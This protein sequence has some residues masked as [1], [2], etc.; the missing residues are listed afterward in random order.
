MVPTNPEVATALINLGAVQMRQGELGNARA[1]LERALAALQE[2]YGPDHPEVAS[3]LVYLGAVQ[4]G[5]G[6]LRRRPRQH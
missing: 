6:E 5:L 1:S 4:L 3:A 2:A